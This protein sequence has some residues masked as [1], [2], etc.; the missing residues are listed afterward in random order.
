VALS[1]STADDTAVDGVGEPAADYSARSE[2][3]VFPQGSTEQSFTVSIANDLA[4]EADEQFFV[5]LAGA[6]NATIA[7]PRATVTII[8]DD[9]PEDQL[10]NLRVQVVL[11]GLPHGKENTLLN[12]ARLDCKSLKSFANDVLNQ[13]GK[14]I[15]LADAIDLLAAVDRLM[16]DL[17]CPPRR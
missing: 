12:K 10:T 6:V 3:L 15:E 2:T 9:S 4:M 13:A 16:A 11:L 5:D 17:G 1:F 8:D 7:T 14:T